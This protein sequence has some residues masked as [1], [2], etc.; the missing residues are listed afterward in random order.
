MR[1]LP[2][3]SLPEAQKTGKI[4]W[5]AKAILSPLASSSSLRLPSSKN[6]SIRLSS[7]S[8]AASTST[9][10]MACARPTSLSGMAFFSGLPPSLGNTY[11]TI[12]SVSMIVL[13]PLPVCKG[14]WKGMTLGPN[15]DLICSR[16]VSKLAFSWSS[17]LTTKRQGV[18]NFSMYSQRSSVPTSTPLAALTIITAVSATLSEDMTSPTK[19]S[20]PG[21]SMMLI[22]FPRHST[23]M[24]ELN[25]EFPLSC[26]IFV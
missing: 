24:S 20:Y 22:L 17:W 19:S 11:M 14:Y 3:L 2:M 18:S 7:F 8:A 12:R 21:V 4:C 5:C 23:C 6:F 16:V 26:S 10:C 9:W 1:P 15:L 13:N 25:K